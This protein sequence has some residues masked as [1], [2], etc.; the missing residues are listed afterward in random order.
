[1]TPWPPSPAKTTFVTAPRAAPLP[2]APGAVPRQASS[3]P[4]AEQAPPAAAAAAFSA[5]SF[6]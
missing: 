6:S 3:P 4:Q 1:M 5:F 2:R